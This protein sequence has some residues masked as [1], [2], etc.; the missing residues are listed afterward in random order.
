M[1]L[2][3]RVTLDASY[4]HCRQ[5]AR[6]S[7]F[8][9]AFF[10]V[11]KDRRRALWAVYAFNRRCDDLS[12][13]IVAMPLIP[14]SQDATEQSIGSR[15]SRDDSRESQ[16]L[17]LTKWR[18]QLDAA[19][20]GHPAGDALWPAFADSVRRYQIPHRCFFDMIDGVSSD[21]TEHTKETFDDLYRYC[22]QVASVVGISVVSIFGAHS[23]DAQTLAEKCGVAVQLTNILRDVKEDLELGRVYLP[24]EDLRQFAVSTIA[25]SPEMRRLL[26]HRAASAREL[27]QSKAPLLAMVDTKTRPCLNAIIGVYE[28]L[29]DKLE[30]QDFAV[31]GDRVRL[32]TRAKL[33]VLAR[34]WL[35]G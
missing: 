13:A 17:A 21:L 5:M 3:W 11:D 14:G 29:L 20:N 16:S 35:N 34:A 23:K 18:E 22:Y 26:R 25:D 8:Y 12:D 33:A 24:Q 28:K 32:S 30:A 7:S 9:P 2:E 27:Y 4:E 31:F 15:Q 1:R 10:L 6:G 19:L